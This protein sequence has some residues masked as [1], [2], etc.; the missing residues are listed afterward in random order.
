M[1]IPCGAFHTGKKHVPLLPVEVTRMVET[2]EGGIL[3]VEADPR[4]TARH[5][6]RALENGV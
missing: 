4:V 5:N 1:V 2:V 3:D 6:P